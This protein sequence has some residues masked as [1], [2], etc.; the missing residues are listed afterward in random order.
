MGQNQLCV[1]FS[2]ANVMVHII[3]S[4]M[5]SP[6]GGL[7]LGVTVPFLD[8]PIS[9]TT[10]VPQKSKYWN[11][12]L[13]RWSSRRAIVWTANVSL[14]KDLRAK[15]WT[16]RWVS[17]EMVRPQFLPLLLSE[18]WVPS[19][20]WQAPTATYPAARNGTDHDKWRGFIPDVC[21]G[22]WKLTDSGSN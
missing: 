20:L 19:A 10:S 5:T 4:W 16:G 6:K 22:K 14:P 17:I 21:D 15:G 3:S 18:T 11:R 8:G 13:P 9:A 1:E 7:I 12:I 2:N